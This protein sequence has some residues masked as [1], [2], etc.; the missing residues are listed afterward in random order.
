MIP[1]R[2]QRP[3]HQFTADVRQNSQWSEQSNDLATMSA[4][5]AQLEG[6]KVHGWIYLYPGAAYQ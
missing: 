4:Q 3:R 5:N 1:L 2:F 6:E